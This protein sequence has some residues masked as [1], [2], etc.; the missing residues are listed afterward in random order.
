MTQA[1]H[2]QTR[3]RRLS[4]YEKYNSRERLSQSFGEH[5][6]ILAAIEAGDRDQAAERMRAHIQASDQTRPDFRKVRVLAHRRL[7]RR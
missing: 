4:E 6:E 2:Q 5:L 7:T 3:L 1:I